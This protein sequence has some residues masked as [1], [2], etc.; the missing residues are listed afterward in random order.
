MQKQHVAMLT[1]VGLGAG[2]AFLLDPGMGKKR[3]KDAAQRA[4]SLA[5][6]S[7]EAMEG[8]ARDLGNRAHGVAAAARQAFL[9]RDEIVDDAVLGER[10][11]AT[12]GRVVSHP[13]AIEVAAED[14]CV[15]LS[16]PVLAGEAEALVAAAAGVRGVVE[17]E[18]RLERHET[19]E[20]VPALQG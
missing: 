6:R 16:G 17:V 12:L 14:G 5:R 9:D 18:D 20:G 8:R 11:R 1:G 2:L 4:G 15:T 7:A 13:R 19:P 3:R 10:V